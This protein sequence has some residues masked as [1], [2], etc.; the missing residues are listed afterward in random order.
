MKQAATHKG[1]CQICDRLQMLPGGMIAKHGYTVKNRGNWGFFSGTCFGSDN[2]PYEQSADLIPPMIENMKKQIEETKK[3]HD[4]VLT[5][6]P[7]AKAWYHEYVTNRY[8]G[9][10]YHWNY[11]DLVEIPHVHQD[12]SYNEYQYINKNGKQARM[13][14]DFDTEKSLDVIKAKM[15]KK[16]ADHIAREIKNMQDYLSWLEK[17]FANFKIADLTQR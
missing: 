10:M 15:N 5:P 17:R 6:K 14:C 11:V 3:H 7:E 1:H 9:G 12:Y 8:F 2:L 4:D 16:Y 13:T